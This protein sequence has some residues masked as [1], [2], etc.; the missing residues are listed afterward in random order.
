[1]DQGNAQTFSTSVF[2]IIR[3]RAATKHELLRDFYV[4]SID[5]SNNNISMHYSLIL[6]FIIYAMV[7]RT[8]SEPK[9]ETSTFKRG[10]SHIIKFN[11]IYPPPDFFQKLT[12]RGQAGWV[13]RF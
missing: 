1:V 11:N 8:I 6:S 3:I 9:R 13:R 5:K 7:L 4:N 12:Q 2:T 10:K